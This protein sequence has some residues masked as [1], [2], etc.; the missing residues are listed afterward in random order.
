MASGGLFDSRS[1][2]MVH[3]RSQ[4]IKQTLETIQGK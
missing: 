1:G 4:L 3:S 2:G